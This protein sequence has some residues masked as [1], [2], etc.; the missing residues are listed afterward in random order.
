MLITE[1]DLFHRRRS[2]EEDNLILL[3]LMYQALGVE[4]Q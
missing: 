1:G 2:L 3:H 4:S